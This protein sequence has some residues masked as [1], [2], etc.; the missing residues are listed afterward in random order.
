[1][2]SVPAAR[3]DEAAK[4]VA[5][6]F[7]AGPVCVCPAVTRQ[8]PDLAPG[9]SQTLAALGAPFVR[10]VVFVVI[11]GLA[12]ALVLL[13]LGFLAIWPPRSAPEWWR[14]T[15][16]RLRHRIRSRHYGHFL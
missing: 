1:M 9:T 3:P 11:V 12:L 14:R 5:A 7:G 13:G 8:L 10:Y 16:R 2:T 6:S 15:T 4:E